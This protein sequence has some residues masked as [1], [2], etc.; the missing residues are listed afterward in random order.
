[1]HETSGTPIRR[2]DDCRPIADRITEGVEMSAYALGH[3]YDPNYPPDVI[4]YL[5]R[6]QD[7]MDPFGGRFI[8][9]NP[10]VD[11]R[12]GEWPG[13]VVILEFPTVEQA[14]AWYESP[15]YQEILPLRTRH[16]RTDAIIVEGVSADYDIRATATALRRAAED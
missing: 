14:R 11:V 8:V 12:E 1:V 7:T 6:I 9:H 15:D 5:D 13:S 10:T 4:D 16:I 3:L 2:A